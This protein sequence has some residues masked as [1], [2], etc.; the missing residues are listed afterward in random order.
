MCAMVWRI[1][2]VRGNGVRR[3]GIFQQR[4]DVLPP[5]LACN[6][7]SGAPLRINLSG[8]YT[9]GKQVSNLAGAVAG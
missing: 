7:Q 8:V 3:G 1:E 5:L 6:I 9:N 2:T 4:Y